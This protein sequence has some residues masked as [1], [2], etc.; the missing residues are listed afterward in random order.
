MKHPDLLRMHFYDRYKIFSD[1]K[2]AEAEAWALKNGFN[3]ETLKD[4]PISADDKGFLFSEKTVI[5]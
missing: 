5:M 3:E 1:D 2:K 4:F